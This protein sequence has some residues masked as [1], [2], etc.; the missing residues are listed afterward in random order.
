MNLL[1]HWLIKLGFHL[2]YHQLAWTYDIVAWG[3]SFGQWAAWRRLALPYTQPGP[4][5]DLA[6]GTGGLFAD[7]L[8]AGYRPAG[9]DRS[10]YMARLAKRRL[11]KKQH[12]APIS[13]ATVQALPFPSGYFASVVA[14]FPTDYIFDRA[15]LA[16]AHRVLKPA[17]RLI[18]VVEG[19][20]RGPWPL[21]PLIDWLYKITGQH[22]FP[23]I[24]PLPLFEQRNFTARWQI[25][26][27]EGASAKLLIAD[28][29]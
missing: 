8:D 7:M 21:R 13:R 16:E 5:L 14:T 1:P 12:P 3:V 11:A 27:R 20:L 28:K 9:I 23:A 24:N 17:G 22:N 15:T 25:A 26:E 19:Q 18:I 4:I 10:P 2:L 29:R 6:Y